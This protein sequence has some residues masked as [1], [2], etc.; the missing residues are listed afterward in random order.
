[1]VAF[2]SILCPQSSERREEHV[3]KTDAIKLNLGKED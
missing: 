2:Q 3:G 1:M